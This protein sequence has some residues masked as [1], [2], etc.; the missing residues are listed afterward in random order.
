M[1][2]RQKIETLAMFAVMFAA[3]L[4]FAFAITS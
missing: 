3:T 2:R 4:W 1:T